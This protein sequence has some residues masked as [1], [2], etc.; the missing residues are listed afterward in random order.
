M[1]I[2]RR[3]KFIYFCALVL[4]ISRKLS[5]KWLTRTFQKNL[6][7]NMKYIGKYLVQKYFWPVTVGHK[8]FYFKIPSK[9]GPNSEILYIW[10]V[11]VYIKLKFSSN[12]EGSGELLSSLG[13]RRPSVRKHFNLLLENHCTKW[14]Q[15]WQKCSFAWSNQVLLLSL[16]SVIQHGCQGP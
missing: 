9:W 10:K 15:T 2:I 14:D 16:R 12:L 8:L 6:R 5:K 11:H 13:V 1:K 7:I 4:K 3:R